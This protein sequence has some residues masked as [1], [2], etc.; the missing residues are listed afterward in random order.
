MS[1]KDNSAVEKSEDLAAKK[2]TTKKENVE[3][4]ADVV[5]VSVDSVTE[6]AETVSETAKSDTAALTERYV[7]IGPTITSTK[8]R[9]RMI[10]RGGRDSVEAYLKDEIKNIPAV[11]NLIIPI[12]QLSKKGELVTKKGTQLYKNYNAVL[13]AASK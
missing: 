11:K 10:I 4:K 3:A 7:Y 2:K 6:K 8:L 5:S 12:E 9:E 1:T 13:K